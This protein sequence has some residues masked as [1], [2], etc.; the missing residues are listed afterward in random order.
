MIAHRGYITISK[1]LK[2]SHLRPPYAKG[3][4]QFF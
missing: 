2:L 1:Q 3:Y 4:L